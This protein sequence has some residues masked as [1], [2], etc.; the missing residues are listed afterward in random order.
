MAINDAAAIVTGPDGQ[1]QSLGEFL[2]ARKQAC[3]LPVTRIAQA[4]GISRANYYLLEKDSQRPSLTT[5]DR[6]FDAMGLKTRVPDD[7][8]PSHAADLVVLAGEEAYKVKVRWSAKERLK[9]RERY[10]SAAS[11][12]VGIALGRLARA[13][14]ADGTRGSLDVAE[15]VAAAATPLG[16]AIVESALDA[17][18][19]RLR[20]RREAHQAEA[21]A[22]PSHD[23][24]L[25]DL[26]QTA[27]SMSTE[28]LEAL[29]AVMKS[30]RANQKDDAEE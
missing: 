18:A 28:E 16:A 27:V 20:E 22:A 4:A 23:Q 29:L 14:R 2:R 25:E 11:H 30:M 13:R 26:K 1:V 12:G 19:L 6:L 5:L 10:L 3:G 9:S 8:D 15:I 21:A 7:Q 24:V 17:A